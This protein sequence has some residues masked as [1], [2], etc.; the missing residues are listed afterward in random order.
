[1]ACVRLATAHCLCVCWLLLAWAGSA[2]AAAEPAAITTAQFLLADDETPPADARDWT[3]LTLPDNWSASRRDAQGIGWYR[4]AFEHGRAADD[5]VAVLVHRL[6]M[7]GEFFVNGVRVLSGGRMTAPVTRNWNTPFFVELPSALLQPGRN[8]LDIRLY[9]YRNSNGGLGTV[10]L[11]DPAALRARHLF[12]QAL[13]VKGAIISFAVALLAAFIAI[14]AWVRMAHDAIF[15]LFGLAMVAW[16]VRYTNYFVQD[17]PIDPVAYAVV[18]N[19]A[20]G[21]FFIFFTP[22]LLR[23]THLRWPRIEQAL[24][25]GG[26]GGHAQHLCGIPGLGAVVERHRH[27][28]AG[29]AAGLGAAVVGVDTACR[30]HPVGVGHA[31]RSSGM[32]VCAIDHTGA[33]DHVQPGAV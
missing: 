6:S 25:I 27:L 15:G 2:F 24:F 8:V 14:V 13:H 3:G 26:G 9:A 31:G 19:S 28:A 5:R 30:P 32:A 10:Y 21:W 17:V 22:F 29:V 18:V 12:L 20:Q 33:A 7:N 23:L 4:M 16:A 11:G 1:M